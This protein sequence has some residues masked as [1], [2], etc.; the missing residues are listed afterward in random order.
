[1]RTILF[2][3][4]LA[5][6]GAAQPATAATPVYIMRHLQKAE[7]ADPPLSPAGAAQ[8]KAL[9]SVLGGG[10]ITAIFAT[11]TQRAMETAAPL[12]KRL[13]LTVT[14]YDPSAPERL[15]EAVRAVHGAVLIIGHSNTVPDLVTRFGGAPAPVIGDGDYGTIFVVDPATHFV[16]RMELPP[17]P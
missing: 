7:G 5:L 10:G 6:L 11:Q 4:I 14:P 16:R 17:A 1:M 2:A 3:V 8:A 12:A 13:G 15:V 9:A